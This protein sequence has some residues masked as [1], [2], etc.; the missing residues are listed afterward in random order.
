MSLS[1][2]VATGNA[3]KARE[4]REMLGRDRFAWTDLGSLGQTVEPPEE[5]GKT[6]RANACLKASYYA[7]ASG[8]WAIADDSGLEVDALDGAP[9]V[10]SARWAE[11]HDAGKGD[12]ANNA[13]LLRQLDEVPDDRRTARFVCVLALTDPGGVVVLT[14]RDT[15]EGVVL[16]APRGTNGFGYD[17]LFYVAR[18]GRTTAELSPDEKHAVSHRGNALR[19]LRAMMER[20]GIG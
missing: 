2:F 10:V 13:L 16:R 9:G 8:S 20:L 17:P 18:F 14:A 3:G 7:R 12:A 5:T 6:F 4:F 15:M 11:L 1:L 19:R